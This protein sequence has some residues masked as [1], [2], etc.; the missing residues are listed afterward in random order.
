MNTTTS[1][2][3]IRKR[4]SLRRLSI[5]Q[6]L[7]FF[8]CV[9]LLTIILT[10]S[11][12]SYIGVQKASLSIGAE[13]VTTLVEQLSKSF[14]ES[15]NNFGVITQA[16]AKEKSVRQFLQTGGGSSRQEAFDALKK[17]ATK[18][19]LSK[20][21]LL[22]DTAGK[23]LLNSGNVE[24][25]AKVDVDSLISPVPDKMQKNAVGKII[26]H[27]GS[28]YYPVIVT[29]K[30]KKKTIGYLVNWRV[31]KATQ[32]SI[33]QLAQ[34][35]GANGKLYFG[36]DDGKFWTD[37]MKPVPRPPA[38]SKALQHVVEYSRKNGELLIGSVRSIPNSR[39][40]ILVEISGSAVMEPA[41]LFLKWVIII[42]IILVIVG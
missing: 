1:G 25:S 41:H 7:P 10:F 4:F 42:G 3:T 38:D 34:I 9:L 6:R 11:W 31:L 22:L 19:T 29:L 39:W 28:M 8:I 26:L 14:K 40:L 17:F 5:Q 32:K 13:R 23:T 20:S 27:K 21:V 33:D 37:L 24:L 12:V 2:H 15:I 30:D 16:V 35:L 36:N 18:D